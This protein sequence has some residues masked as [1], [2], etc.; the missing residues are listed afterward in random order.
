MRALAM[1][2]LALA[3]L[4]G[5][6]LPPR[7][8]AEWL[9]GI[10]DLRTGAVTMGLWLWKALLLAHSVLFWVWLKRAEPRRST[11][12]GVGYDSGEQWLTPR[13][14]G[15]ALASIVVVALVL[16]VVGLG[17][18]LW[19][20]EIKMYVLYM[21]EPLGTILATYDDQNQHLL[22]SL[23]ARLSTLVYGDGAAAL[24]MPALV[25]G[26][27][28]I[29][30]AYS[31]GTR[32]TSRRES[33]LVALLLAVSYHHVW[34]S[35][36]ARGYTG[37]LLW[38]IIATILFLDLLKN[39]DASRRGLPVLYGCAI[40]LGLYTHLTA[41]VLPAAHAMIAAWAWWGPEAKS[42]ERPAGMPLLVGL[43]L[44]GTLSILLYAPVLP[45]VGSVLFEPSFEGREVAWKTPSWFF[46]ELLGGLTAGVPGGVFGLLAGAGVAGVG[47][48][49]FWKRWS[50]AALA[51]VVPVVLTA[52]AI[53][54]LGHNLWPRFFFFAAAFVVLIGFRG[55]FDLAGRVGKWGPTIATVVA[56]LV[57]GGSLATVAPVWGNKQDH[58]GAEALVDASATP[59]DAVVIVDMAILP[60][61]RWRGRDWLEVHRADELAEVEAA[62]E[63]TW[64]LYSFPT[65]LRAL[66]P[67]VWERIE[68]EYRE[69][70]RFPGTVRGGD[71]LVMVRE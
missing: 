68:S 44:A 19:F 53:L 51:M 39:R 25:F 16:R 42:E 37:L 29:V 46:T 58:E 45:Q 62:H 40:A 20:D 30:A 15:L 64:L 5:A 12:D 38:S 11:G 23:L 57:A 60:Y 4:I 9:V 18:R 26:I 55:L 47:F 24:R 32:V 34:F 43:V 1:I 50:S 54:A 28:S 49:S 69:V 56:V 21:T 3:A 22:Y 2:G 41:A 65:S 70:E 17:D 27:A 48:W 67:D 6:A 8:T 59:D 66:E 35:Q 36:N 63:R 31:L 13:R 52:I 33:L 7:A 61:R 10:G 14:A 71:I